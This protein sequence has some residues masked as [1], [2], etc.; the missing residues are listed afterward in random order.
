MV[1]RDFSD[2][3]FE[4]MKQS[5]HSFFGLRYSAIDFREKGY[6]YAFCHNGGVDAVDSAQ[7]LKDDHDQCIAEL[8]RVFQS[9]KDYDA[10]SHSRIAPVKEQLSAFRQMVCS[11]RDIINP[12]PESGQCALALPPVELAQRLGVND[13]I[14]V[15]IVTRRF[16]TLDENGNPVYNW[17]EIERVLNK[18]IEEINLLEYYVLASL[19]PNMNTEDME[20]LVQRLAEHRWD[21]RGEWSNNGELQDMVGEA[22]VYDY[23]N[24]VFDGT[25]LGLLLYYLGS[26]MMGQGQEGFPP[27][28]VDDLSNLA[29]NYAVLSSL[30][31]L[32]GLMS[33]SDSEGYP[34]FSIATNPETGDYSLW[35]EYND[36]LDCSIHSGEPA[37]I[38]IG[39]INLVLPQPAGNAAEDFNNFWNN[40]QA[41]E[42]GHK[43][44]DDIPNLVLEGLGYIPL[45][46]LN[47][48]NSI[49][50]IGLST[51]ESV[52][53]TQFS[54]SLSVALNDSS[55]MNKV[56]QPF[57]CTVAL[58]NFGDSMIVIPVPTQRT[59]ET[60][61]GLNNVLVANN[62][63]HLISDA[64]LGVW[65][66]T[67][68]ALI[69]NPEGAK[70]LMSAIAAQT[71]ASGNN[72]GLYDQIFD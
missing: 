10:Q 41:D 66:I 56:Y 72:L 51:E 18:P 57:D 3:A 20:R 24:W 61:N 40:R 36:R 15:Q 34:P 38:K 69:G 5:Y 29:A 17:D 23:T 1:F 44:S 65:P 2:E 30:S 33:G 49:V 13:E 32:S 67:F 62:S 64:G 70:E 25:K 37:P 50:G 14:L 26:F 54:Q 9:V 8:Q 42:L 48:I 43:P 27:V 31:L 68:E 6:Y 52:R 28:V 60:I 59:Q 71:D 46:P 12:Y 16:M 39:H 63:E 47:I 4:S 53:L 35:F 21:N 19:I 58:A 7:R 22:A 55:V 11:L 45:L